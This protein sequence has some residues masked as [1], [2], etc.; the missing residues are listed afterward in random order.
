MSELVVNV[1]R[2][3]AGV[4]VE[5]LYAVLRT[6]SRSGF[7]P[8]NVWELVVWLREWLSDVNWRLVPDEDEVVIFWRDNPQALLVVTCKRSL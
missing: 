2:V 5:W 1:Q 7:V 3:G 6:A 4:Y 8:C